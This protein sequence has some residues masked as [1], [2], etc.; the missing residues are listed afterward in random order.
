MEPS[1]MEIMGIIITSIFLAIMMCTVLV[2]MK[3]PMQLLADDCNET[4]NGTF[5]LES[6]GCPGKF[7]FGNCINC[8]CGEIK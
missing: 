7:Q 5:F 6:G 4:C 3:E 8:V 1:I 2:G